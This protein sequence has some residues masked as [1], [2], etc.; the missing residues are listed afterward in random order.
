ML[1]LSRRTDEAIVFPNLG[2]T[3]KILR[4][5][6]RAA[7]IGIEAP[8]EI[9]ILR[10]EVARATESME[11][12]GSVVDQ[13]PGVPR[14]ELH[15]IRNRLNTINLG[16][17]LYRQQ[18]SAGLIDE[19][20][21][22]FLRV[23]DDL[24]KVDQAAASL[25]ERKAEA[26]KALNGIRLLVVEDDP[27]QRELLAGFLKMRGC[28]VATAGN[29]AEAL[30]YLAANVWPDFVLLDLRMPECNGADFVRTLRELPSK[31]DMQILAISGTSPVELGISS[32]VD[33]W[34]PKPLNP[35][36][37]VNRMTG[38]AVRNRPSSTAAKALV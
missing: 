4:V 22:T 11:I 24:E 36:S 32:G 23:V 30:D 34:F 8:A 15:A 7:R 17:H 9:R 29:G 5:D 16:L 31:A 38:D 21:L 1:V 6:R 2:I 14:S 28:A 35:E 33:D 13:L 10:K 37:L 26:E 27:T 19:A 18:M 12:D 20:N 25:D 3:V